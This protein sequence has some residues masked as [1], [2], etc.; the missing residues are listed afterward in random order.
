VTQLE[1]ENTSIKAPLPA[2]I[3][4]KALEYSAGAYRFNRALGTLLS[5]S[6]R[7]I[8]LSERH[9]NKLL[10]KFPHLNG[11][12]LVIPPP[13]IIRMC[14]DAGFDRQ[15]TR[16]ALGVKPA[17]FLLAYFGYVYKGKGVE[18]LIGALSLLRQRGQGSARGRRRRR[19]SGRLRTSGRCSIWRSAWG[20]T[21][22]LSGRA[23]M[24]PIATKRRDTSRR[25]R[26]RPAVR[27]RRDA[28]SKLAC[29]S[30]TYGRAIV[31]T[32]G[33]ALSQPWIAKRHLCH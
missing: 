5:V 12:S 11:K 23:N 17:D 4:F 21:T 10:D 15:Q 19:S 2:R 27:R 16:A 32:R 31:T 29:S 22:I 3:V 18:T 30:G 25:R 28:Q 7:V 13:P 20:C 24:T 14:T 9:E 26:L 6:D 33:L 1:I 8:T